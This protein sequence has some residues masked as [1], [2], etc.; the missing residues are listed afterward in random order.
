MKFHIHSE[1]KI[2][3]KKRKILDYFRFQY[4]SENHESIYEI[5]N[6][7]TERHRWFTE[8]LYQ[9]NKEFQVFS[10]IRGKGLLIGCQLN[11]N[12]AGQAKTITNLAAA[13][14]LIA[15]IAGPDVIRFAPALNI[16]HEEF[17]VGMAA[18]SRALAKFLQR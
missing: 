15:L 6:G 9:L 4:L 18:F 5:L 8:A 11:S 2:K 12:Y 17:R 16:S 13:E 14:G 10:E 7:V 3:L 1:S